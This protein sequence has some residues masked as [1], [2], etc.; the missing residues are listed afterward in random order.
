FLLRTEVAHIF[1]AKGLT[2]ELVEYFCAI[3][4]LIWLFVGL[5]FVANASFNNLGFPLLS[6][7]FNWGRATLGM[8]P[9]AYFGAMIAGPK[10]ALTGIGA[11]SVAFGIAAILTSFWTIRRL[12]RQAKAR[13]AS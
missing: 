3:S 6:T 8:I 11:G 9:F 7:F 13:L 4:G 5:V 1:Q 10:G 12:E 2:A